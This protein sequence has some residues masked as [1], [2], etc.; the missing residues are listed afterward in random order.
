[1]RRKPLRLV[2]GGDGYLGGDRLAAAARDDLS[3]PLRARLVVPTRETTSAGHQA[4]GGN[5]EEGR[6]GVARR[7]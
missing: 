2:A 3:V 4:G 5:S 1:M 7:V 6:L